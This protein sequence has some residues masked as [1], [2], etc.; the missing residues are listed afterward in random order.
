MKKMWIF[1]V[2]SRPWCAGD[3]QG[4]VSELQHPKFFLKILRNRSLR[5]DRRTTDK[6]NM[7]TTSFS[8]AA[9]FFFCTNQKPV[10]CEQVRL[11]CFCHKQEESLE[12]VH[13]ESFYR[14]KVVSFLI[15]CI[16]EGSLTNWLNWA[17]LWICS[18]LRLT[19][20]PVFCHKDWRQGQLFASSQGT[21]ARHCGKLSLE[22]CQCEA[23]VFN[24]IFM[25]VHCTVHH[26]LFIVFLN[27]VGF[28]IYWLV[29]SYSWSAAICFYTWSN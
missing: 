1:S 3:D 14:F 26:K 6:V 21:N 20:K 28:Y 12:T 23:S 11:S 27:K 9:R 4:Q 15:S 16:T 22:F 18:L 5:R 17:F 24:T 29:T 7:L 19:T 25:S 8:S 10:T 2:F 13:V